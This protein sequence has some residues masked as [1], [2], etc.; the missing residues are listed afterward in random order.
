LSGAQDI[1]ANYAAIQRE[2]SREAHSG[3][4]RNGFL[5]VGDAKM[6]LQQAAAKVL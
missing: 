3:L 6:E 5:P 2:R 1:R 4:G